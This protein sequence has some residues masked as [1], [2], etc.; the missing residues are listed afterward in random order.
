[1]KQYERLRH[2]DKAFV[3]G[4]WMGPNP[5]ILLEE[6]CGGLDLRPGMR[7]LDLGCGKGLTSIFLAKE[8]GVTVY[9]CDLW[10]SAT[11]NFKRFEQAGVA[12]RVCPIHAEAH[13]LPFADSFFDAAVSI[14]S[15]HYYGAD[16]DYFKDIFSGL[17][18][19]GG[20]FGIACPGLTR[21]LGG[22]IPH[23]LR[24]FWQDEMDAFSTFHATSWW[25]EL[26]RQSGLVRV[27]DCREIEGARDIW[28][29]WAD[30][31]KE[32][33]GFKDRELLDADKDGLL[34]LF[35]MTAVKN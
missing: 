16:A 18:K 26:W 8:F 29:G 19:S 22:E 17:V 12:E 2:Y 11:E 9:A 28:S 15:Y 27:T 23:S 25:A 20:Q 13:A 1:L 24:G 35:M 31:A 34:T 33:L 4:N 6:V 7:V 32:H 5:L 10:I 30:W 14:D 21:E 3:E